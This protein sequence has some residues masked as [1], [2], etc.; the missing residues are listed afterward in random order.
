M[1]MS[2]KMI[3]TLDGP[4]GVDFD[5][6]VRRD[7]PPTTDSDGYEARSYSPGPDETLVFEPSS[8][9]LYYIMVRSYSGAGDFRLRV[10]P[11]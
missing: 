6:Y 11:K 9:G 3:I 4:G 2:A 7:V 1:Q 10:K 5:L 8:P